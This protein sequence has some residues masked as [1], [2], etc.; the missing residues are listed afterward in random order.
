VCAEKVC[1]M[2]E[3]NDMESLDDLADEIIAGPKGA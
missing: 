1:Q 3:D 2:L